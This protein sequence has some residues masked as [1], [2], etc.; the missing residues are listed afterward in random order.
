M[1]FVITVLPPSVKTSTEIP[2]HYTV[3]S[4]FLHFQRTWWA[5]IRGILISPINL[6][7]SNG[8]LDPFEFKG[9]RF[10]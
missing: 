5:D 4:C 8:R 10:L 7:F 2:G 1:L 6:T 9:R 3:H